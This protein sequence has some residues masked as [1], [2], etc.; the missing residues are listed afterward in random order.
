MKINSGKQQF[1][2]GDCLELMNQIP[3]KTIDVVIADLP[4][5]ITQSA[6]DCVIPLDQLWSHYKRIAKDNTPFILFASQ[7]FTYKL[8]GSNFKWFKYCWYWEKEK[9]TGFLNAKKQPLRCIEEICVFYNKAGKYNPQM[10][11]LD[12]PIKRNLPTKSTET[13]NPVGSF[14]KKIEYKEYTHSYPKN[15]RGIT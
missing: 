2:L 1:W 7:P 8:I 15:R 14:G 3:N 5:G 12:K 9:G 10:K 4:Y 6:W 11:K 13:V